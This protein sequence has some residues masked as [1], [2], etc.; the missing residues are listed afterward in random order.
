MS[1]MNLYFAWKLMQSVYTAAYNW[2][3]GRTTFS[4]IRAANHKLDLDVVF[5]LE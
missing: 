2:R 1:S 3:C 4:V 5:K